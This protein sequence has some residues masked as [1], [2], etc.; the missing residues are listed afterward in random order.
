MLPATKTSILCSA[1]DPHARTPASPPPRAE[2]PPSG[3]SCAPPRRLP[4]RMSRERSVPRA[5]RLGTS[6][7][8]SR[9]SKRAA[10]RWVCCLLSRSTVTTTL[11]AG[12]HAACALAVFR[13]PVLA[14]SVAVTCAALPDWSLF[15]HLRWREEIVHQLLPARGSQWNAG[16]AAERVESWPDCH[17]PACQASAPLYKPLSTVRFA[18]GPSATVRR[19]FTPEPTQRCSAGPTAPNGSSIAHCSAAVAES[20][21][22]PARLISCLRPLRPA[23]GT[24]PA[25][26]DSAILVYPLLSPPPC[27]PP[28]LTARHPR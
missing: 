24:L 5:Q 28:R 15:A 1:G 26:F 16:V 21:R 20:L 6:A 25:C 8:A 4:S 27:P 22:C 12:L 19:R 11:A 13:L 9:A 10:G 23:G 7:K 3:P 14:T 2:L 18:A 17:Q